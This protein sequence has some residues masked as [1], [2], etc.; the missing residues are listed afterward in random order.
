[1]RFRGDGKDST[2]AARPA[3]IT[4]V[5]VAGGVD[6]NLIEN[7]EMVVHA[8]CDWRRLEVQFKESTQCGNEVGSTRLFGDSPQ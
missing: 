5:A 8:E 4:D 1:M 7:V 6:T 3:L 2:D